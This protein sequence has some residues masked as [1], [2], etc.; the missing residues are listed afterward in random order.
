MSL[1]GL[2]LSSINFVAFS[3]Y[4]RAFLVTCAGNIPCG[5]LDI[6]AC[7]DHLF[8]VSGCCLC[9]SAIGALQQLL[10]ISCGFL[11]FAAPLLKTSW[12]AC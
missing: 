1:P 4:I 6:I 2:S 9:A 11:I 5:I 8:A 3:W 10:L 7:A 12:A